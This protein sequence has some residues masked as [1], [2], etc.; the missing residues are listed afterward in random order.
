MNKQQLIEVYVKYKFFPF[1]SIVIVFSIILTFF[2]IY[3]Q[4]Q[5]L[6][7]DQDKIREL[8]R[9][10]TLLEDKAQKLEGLDEDDLKEKLAVALRTL[11]VETDFANALGMIQTLANTYQFIIVNFHTS[12][13]SEK[14]AL[15]L[16]SYS[17][18]LDLIGPKAL[19]QRFIDSINENSRLMRTIYIQ[20]DL[21]GKENEA[22]IVLS[23]DVFYSMIPSTI[24][25]VDAPVVEISTKDQEL[26]SELARS[27][28]AAEVQPI[29]TGPRGKANPFE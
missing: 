9:K 14:E 13:S 15:K 24:G 22:S 23:V 10:T 3:P 11:P 19:V 29:L 16:T 25:A 20:T 5:K 7:S 26:I 1:S 12:L 27:Q 8:N 21:A 4:I 18:G 2:V 28:P 6:I 17:I